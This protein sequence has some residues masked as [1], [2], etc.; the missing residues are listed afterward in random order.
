MH[1]NRNTIKHKQ[2]VGPSSPHSLP[3][4]MLFASKKLHFCWSVDSLG[5]KVCLNSTEKPLSFTLWP[6]WLCYFFISG[7]HFSGLLS[8]FISLS[9]CLSLSSV[10]MFYLILIHPSSNFFPHSFYH[11]F[12]H[13]SFSQNTFFGDLFYLR[14]SLHFWLCVTPPHRPPSSFPFLS[15]SMWVHSSG[16]FVF[17]TC[18][19]VICCATVQ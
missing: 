15:L 5:M 16:S 19:L 2:A 11:L 17:L 14:W 13:F 3:R 1:K 8:I 12:F 9:P 18:H 7:L 4:L 10:G 6:Y